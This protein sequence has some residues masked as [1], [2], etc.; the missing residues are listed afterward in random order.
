[1]KKFL[2]SKKG[3]ALLATMVAAVAAAVGAYAYFTNIG[4]GTGSATVG[5]SDVIAL[6]GDVADSLYP[7]GADAPV[8]VSI[9]NPGSGTQHVGTISGTVA[10][11]GECLGEWFV[12]DSINYDADLLAGTS[13]TADTAVRMLDSGAPQDVCQGK[14]LTITWSSN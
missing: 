12:V 7:G 1:M 10:N 6:S 11:N 14:S 8:T 9:S 13:D 3:I 4:T 5:S 2:K